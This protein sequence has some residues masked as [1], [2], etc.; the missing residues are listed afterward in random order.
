MDGGLT[1]LTPLPPTRLFERGVRVCCLPVRSLSAGGG[2]LVP[3]ADIAPDA[4]GRGTST[5]LAR[6]LRLALFP[7]SDRE[8]EELLARG[9]RD[10]R[11]WIL[12]S[13]A[14]ARER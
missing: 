4:F 13:G 9:A 7:G 14:E 6:S 12:A 8:K 10:A 2:V 11:R 5:S 1:D 3:P